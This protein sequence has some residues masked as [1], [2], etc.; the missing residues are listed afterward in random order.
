MDHQAALSRGR[1]ECDNAQLL[2]D[3]MARLPKC[4]C[5]SAVPMQLAGS[6][7]RAV[8]RG[9]Y[10]LPSAFISDAGIG[11]LSLLQPRNLRAGQST[12]MQAGRHQRAG[13][14][15]FVQ[16]CEIRRFAYPTGGID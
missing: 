14:A 11:A 9:R 8:S 1:G 6:H 13:D 10:R 3:D 16:H 7:R 15:E 12:V 4:H 5:S 2:V